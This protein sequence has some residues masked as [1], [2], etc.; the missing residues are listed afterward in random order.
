[1]A[2]NVWNYIPQA[3]KWKDI[4]TKKLKK[5]LKNRIS[6]FQFFLSIN[7]T[8]INFFPLLKIHFE[9]Y[10]HL[11]SPLKYHKNLPKTTYQFQ[12]T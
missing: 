10:F 2:S 1:M 4:V 9:S 8:E 12:N 6:F 3:Q 11:K 5:N 7:R